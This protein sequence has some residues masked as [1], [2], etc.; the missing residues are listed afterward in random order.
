MDLRSVPSCGP[1]SSGGGGHGIFESDTDPG[2][3]YVALG[4][5]DLDAVGTRQHDR[6]EAILGQVVAR[7]TMRDVL[8]SIFSSGDVHA[9]TARRPLWA[10]AGRRVELICGAYATEWDAGDGTP[11][12]AATQSILAIEY[13]RMK[14]EVAAG[15]MAADA[16]KRQLSKW[17]RRFTLPEDGYRLFLGGERDEGFLAPR[18][19]ATDLFNRSDN[20]DLNAGG[21]GWTER[22]GGYE[23]VSNRLVGIS[24]GSNSNNVHLT[25]WAGGADYWIESNWY[26]VTGFNYQGFIIRR[27]NYSTTDNDSYQF[28]VWGSTAMGMWKRVSGGYTQLGAGSGWSTITAGVDNLWKLEL[29]GTTY[30]VD[31]DGTEHVS[32]T[33]SSISAAGD[34]GF[35]S[36]GNYVSA[37]DV[38]VDDGAGG[39]PAGQP[40]RKRWGGVPHGVGSRG[41]W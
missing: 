20:T 6:V 7:G 16:H 11:F 41:V 4:E 13:L 30:T 22:N 32:G 34:A 35:K 2:S 26:A 12:W 8:G 17:V 29:S 9:R 14:T 38:T 5:G 23:I 15:R 10:G 24:G 3:D 21:A 39:A 27:V 18:T 31:Q 36:D 28:L 40:T 1:P 25:S 37:D 19:S 33:D